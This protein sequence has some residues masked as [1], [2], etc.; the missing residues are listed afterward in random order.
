MRSKLLATTLA[1]VLLGGASFAHAQD[2]GWYAGLGVGQSLVDERGYDDED[3]AFSAF[4]GYQ[5]HRNFALE[6]GY[7]DHGKLKPDGAGQNLD[8]T[9]ASLAAVGIVPFTDRFSGYAKAGIQ[10]WDLKRTLPDLTGTGK[11]DGTDP[12]Y[13]L[14]LQYRFTDAVALRGEYVRSEFEDADVDTAQVQVRFDF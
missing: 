8:A 5:F 6:A 12:L 7:T 9:S 1:A 11:G 4:G 14:G 3:T 2:T 10:R 13:G